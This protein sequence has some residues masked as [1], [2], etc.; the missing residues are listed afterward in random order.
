MEHMKNTDSVNPM[1]APLTPQLPIAGTE[2]YEEIKDVAKLRATGFY[3]PDEPL[4][5]ARESTWEKYWR[6]YSVQE[7]LLVIPAG[8]VMELF[9]PGHGVVQACCVVWF[10]LQPFLVFDVVHRVKRSRPP[11]DMGKVWPA[12][13]CSVGPWVLFIPLWNTLTAPGPLVGYFA[14]LLVWGVFFRWLARD[15]WR[16]RW[17]PRFWVGVSYLA[18]S[19]FALGAAAGLWLAFVA[20]PLASGAPPE[21]LPFLIPLALIGMGI[22]GLSA[23]SAVKFWAAARKRSEA[24]AET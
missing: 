22:A 19:M 9:S 5:P 20:W 7:G 13:V 8:V 17:S 16:P 18:V 4:P 10:L 1:D 15:S 14:F 11:G 12:L 2:A 23:W 24:S 6:H 21:T 3:A